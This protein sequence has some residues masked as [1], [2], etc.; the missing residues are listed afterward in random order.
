MATAGVTWARSHNSWLLLTFDDNANANLIPTVL[1]GD[2]IATGSYSE[3]VDHYTVLRTI[4]DAF[5]LTPIGQSAAESPILDIWAD[6]TTPTAA[7]TA[8]ASGLGVSVNAAASA[9]PDGTITDYS[10]TFGDGGTQNG[11][12]AT[13]TYTPAGAYSVTLTGSSVSAYL[14]GVSST[15]SDTSLTLSLD[16]VTTGSG[17]YVSLVGRRV[18]GAGDY[19]VKARLT[20]TGQFTLVPERVNASNVETEIGPTA[21][22]IAYGAGAKLH[23]RLQVTGRSPTTIRVRAGP[24]GDAE[25][26]TW[27]ATATDSTSALQSAGSIGLTDYLSSGATNTP[28]TVTVDDLLTTKVP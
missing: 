3:A 4:E 12:T 26:T 16:K 24:D 18:T 9:D 17:L 13:H 28:L 20:P 19:R 25:P 11:V 14:S 21:P 2:G 23:L 7:F 27:A 10:W 8:T 1:V 6:S 5:G 22:G 15:A